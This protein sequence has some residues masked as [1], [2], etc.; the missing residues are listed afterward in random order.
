M[1]NDE[2]F[3]DLEFYPG[4]TSLGKKVYQESQDIKGIQWIRASNM[5]S[6]PI[7]FDTIEPTDVAQG[8]ISNC[9]LMAA[10][11]AITEFGDFIKYQIFSNHP[12]NL[13]SS[14]NK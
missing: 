7:L 11:G 12:T 9:W 5:H 4:E 13:I 1:N 10:M 3:K 2:H 8:K 6:N 14:D